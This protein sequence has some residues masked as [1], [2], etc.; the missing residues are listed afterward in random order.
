MSTKNGGGS[1]SAD[2][3]LSLR[4]EVHFSRLQTQLSHRQRT[5]WLTSPSSKAP[6]HYGRRVGREKSLGDRRRSRML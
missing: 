1:S 6:G 4:T 3:S 2:S 5:V